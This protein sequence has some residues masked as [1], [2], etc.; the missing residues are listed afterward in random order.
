[1][2]RSQ[3]RLALLQAVPSRWQLQANF[4]LFLGLLDGASEA[5]AE[6][7]VTPE[8]WLDGYAAADQACTPEKLRTVAQPL[9]HSP[10]LRRVAA[11]ARSR[12]MHLCFGF[13]SRQRGRLHNAA[14]LWDARGRLIGVYHKTHLQSHDLQYAPGAALPAWPTTW[15]SIGILI[16]ADR[17]WPEAARTLRLQGARLILIPSYGMHHEANEWW[18]RTRGYENQC[19][20]AFVHPR[21]AFLVGPD[22]SLEAKR[23]EQQPGVLVCDLDLARARDDNH[24][25]DRRPEL[26]GIITQPRP[27]A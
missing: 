26:Y 17:R 4:D 19:F 2:A 18:M 14:G 3:L 24:L 20:V 9:R 21:V 15:G 6:L 23:Q 27:P 12:K 1:M 5:G 13:S 7:L 25:R 10:Y 8:A 16:C 11:E 22:G